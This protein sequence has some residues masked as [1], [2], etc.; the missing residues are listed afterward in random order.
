[1][2]EEKQN[3]HVKM[4]TFQ[5]E[6]I[7]G[8]PKLPVGPPKKGTREHEQRMREVDSLYD[9]YTDLMKTPK[10]ISHIEFEKFK[11]LFCRKNL[12]GINPMDETQTGP[13][14]ELSEELLTIVDKYREFHVRQADGSYHTYPPIFTPVALLSNDRNDAL[15][16]FKN[17]LEKCGDQPWKRNEATANFIDALYKSQNPEL[18]VAQSRKFNKIAAKLHE[19]VINKDKPKSSLKKEEDKA[20]VVENKVDNGII[21]DMDFVLD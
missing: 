12:E 18:V 21:S 7:D 20:E 4:T 14:R 19:E 8:V 17:L 6:K 10:V 13:L 3:D 2:A 15:D 5:T 1:M 11:P 16:I 9:I